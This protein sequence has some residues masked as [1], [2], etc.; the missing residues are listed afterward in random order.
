MATMKDIARRAGVSYGTV[1]NVLNK[2]GNASL[3]KIKA[4]EKAAE[5]LGYY[6]NS[7]ASELRSNKKEDIALIIP[8][9]DNDMLKKL[10]NLLRKKFSIDGFKLNLYITDFNVVLEEEYAKMA[11][12]NNKYLLINTCFKDTN[13]IYNTNL[14]NDSIIIFLNNHTQTI[15]SNIYSIN[16]DANQITSDINKY[17]E[18]HNYKNALFFSDFDVIDKSKLDTS[19]IDYYQCSQP[20][21]ISTALDTLSN[22]TYEL[23]ITTSLEKYKDIVAVKKILQINSPIKIILI[24]ENN[25]WINPDIK[26]Y[27]QDINHFAD[28]I[29]AIIEG[30]SQ[31]NNNINVSYEGFS[32]VEIR[33]NNK[34]FI[35]LLMIESPATN[36]L[37][38]I[39]PYIEKQLGFSINIDIINYN[40]Y[41][42]VIDQKT[43]EKYDM[44]RIDMAY[45]DSIADKIFKPLNDDIKSLKKQFI[46][47]IDEFVYHNNIM[48]TFPFD[49]GCQ[50]LM[51]RSDIL[52]NQIIKRTYYET[53]K[54]SEILP[55]N[56]EEFNS[57]ESFFNSNYSDKLKGAT[58]CTGSSI[59]CGN[60][61]LIRVPY[62]NIL[63]KEGKL[64]LENI[65]VKKALDNYIDSVKYS[66]R[67]NLFWDGVIKDYSKGKTVMSI[68]FSN[69]IHLL[70]EYNQDILYKTDY[71][72]PP[73]N[74]SLIGGGVIGLSKHTKKDK[75]CH[76]FLKTIYSNQIS[77]L[78]VHLGG[79]IPTKAIFNNINLTSMYPWLRLIPSVLKNNTRKHYDSNGNLYP[80]IDYEKNIGREVKNCLAEHF[81]NSNINN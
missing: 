38:K 21:N 50:I 22:K 69:Y 78:L 18:K 60:E 76:D 77:E 53:T 36:A 49:I 25:I 1:S 41:D 51:Y 10:Y 72:L 63:N 81:K 9:I 73:S 79:A 5:E 55:R 15:R 32:N 27:R 35:N 71:S 70:K 52:N 64:D 4:V 42:T 61:F 45:M 43:I 47:N 6:I 68:I 16:F 28:H 31:Q 13:N 19:I 33:S 23:I 11:T 3:V 2:R 57:I 44:I 8:T 30:N 34:D 62:N 80:T 75:L 24:S 65:E 26:I 20:F 29:I 39:K 54:Q 48:Y 46:K 37:L 12:R 74:R 67:I 59:T 58:V 40:Q 66:D 14:F 56:Y 7:K 17:I